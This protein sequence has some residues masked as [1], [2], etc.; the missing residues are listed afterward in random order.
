MAGKAAKKA[1]SA[2][3]E[4][5]DEGEVPSSKF[6]APQEKG[7]QNGLGLE[8]LF[9]NGP[10][11]LAP[12]EAADDTEVEA[13]DESTPDHDDKKK[14]PPKDPKTGRFL[15]VKQESE[16]PIEDAKPD[17]DQDTLKKRLKDTRDW[18]S[19]VNK[20]NQELDAQLRKLEADHKALADKLNGVAPDVTSKDVDPVEMAKLNERARI[21]KAIAEQVYGPDVVQELIYAEN[22]PYRQLEQADPYV[23]ARVFQAEQPV[24]EAIKQLK[25]KNFT[26]SYGNDPDDVVAKITEEVKA[27]FV[28]NLK[29]RS[30][31]KRTIEDVGGLHDVGGH[32]E[33]TRVESHQAVKEV[34][35]RSVFPGFPTGSF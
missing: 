32:G 4:T 8:H 7:L 19:Q 12:K 27:E 2:A 31:G 15:K 23:K 6:G 9:P 18:A 10:V 3:V 26:D 35:L 34:D 25:W 13:E 14:T 20:R 22:S 24:M 30:R 33:D 11:K 21:S 17:D 29:D 5:L 1:A 28:K 16:P